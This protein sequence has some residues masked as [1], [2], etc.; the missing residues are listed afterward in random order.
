MYRNA[1]THAAGVVIGRQPLI[2]VVPLYRD[3][4]SDIL[5]TQYSMKYVEQASLVKFD[6]LG[7]KTL[8]VIEQAL[9]ILK[10]QG[11]EV[12]IAAHPARRREDLR[13]APPRRRRR[14][15]PVRRP[16]HAGLPAPDAGG[17]LRGP[18]R[19]RR[20]LPPR[21]DGQHPRLLRPQA[22]RALGEPAPGDPPHPG[23]DQRHHG[24]PG[25]GDAD[26]AGAGGLLARRRRPAAPRH[27]Q[28]DPRRDGE[29]ARDLRRGRHR[30]A[31]SPPP[32]P[33]RSST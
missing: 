19:R 29:A 16:G 12:D 8:T 21:P 26:R 10:G 9:A 22:R 5:I 14:G 25:A 2:E 15:V 7:L 11:I 24:L 23:R 30:R 4:R 27:G 17:P 31:A 6:F 28:E 1:S 13:D 3:P 18:G 20:A 32:R 33:A